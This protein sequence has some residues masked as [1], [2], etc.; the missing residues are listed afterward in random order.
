MPQIT[1][2]DYA[3]LIHLHDNFVPQI[4]NSMSKEQIVDTLLQKLVQEPD[5]PQ[6]VEIPDDHKE[7][8]KVLKALLNMRAPKPLDPQFLSMMDTLL[9][10]ELKEKGIVDVNKLDPVSSL[11]PRN[12]FSQSD[13]FILWQGDIT[14]L[15]ADAITNAANSQMLGCFRPYHACIDNAIH[16]SAGPQL[17][18]DCN[19]IMTTQG[20]PE[21]TGRAKITRAYNLPS[22]FVLHTV[23]PIV[24]GNSTVTEQQKK[25]LASCYVSCLELASKL[26]QIKSIVFCG[27]STGVFGFPKSAAAQI[28]VHTVN[29]WLSKH[30]N[31]VERIIFN[32]FGDEDYIE[33]AKIFG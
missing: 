1:L 3:S 20:E 31:R 12:S 7:K 5:A 17:R 22:R 10:K 30:P 16:S 21:E 15:N 4:M 26:P 25:E 13:R 6:D 24:S 19:I 2:Q 32:V 28:A 33:Y 14:Q 9:Q 11:F 18:R 23:G 27:I 29:E 8:R